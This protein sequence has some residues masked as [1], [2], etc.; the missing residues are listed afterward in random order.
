MNAK[1]LVDLVKVRL[2]RLSERRR[3][4]RVMARRH[5]LGWGQPVGETIRYVAEV[6]GKWVALLVFG[7]AAYALEDRDTWIGW[8]GEQRRGRLN[9][10]AQ[11]RRFLILLDQREPNLASRIL[12]LCTRRLADDWQEAYGHPIVGLETFVDPQRFQGTCYRAAGWEPLGLTEGCRRIRRDWYD[13]SGAPKQLFVK[14]L[15]RDAKSLLCAPEL[16]TAWQ[17]H[18]LGVLARSP[19]RTEH[20]RSLWQAYA[21][22]PEF[23]H[24][25][26]LR[27][28]LA[29]VLAC[30]A[31]AVLAGAEGLGEAAEIIAGLEQRQLRALRCYRR[32]SSGRYEPPSEST[33]RRALSGL[34]TERFDTV[35]AQWVS[36]HEDIAAVALDGKAMR[37]C[38]NAEGKPLFLVSAVAHGTGAF[39]GQVQV[40]GK[41]NEIPAARQLLAQMGPLDGVMV[42]TDA[43]HT[44]VET[45]Q[46]VVLEQ[47]ADYLS[48]IKGNQ[49]SLLRKA[50][51]HLPV[52]HF[53]SDGRTG[54]K[55]KR[56][57]GNP[58]DSSRGGDG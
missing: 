2:M 8:S 48:P 15:R 29:S 22:I 39:Q 37:G 14:L 42:T 6:R 31:C 41:S 17:K 7:A 24:A 11:N 40:D 55:T 57:G 13:H 26:G 21:Q 44:Q 50:R 54:G 56:T 12:G 1:S 45:A 33:L 32:R 49:P 46:V 4:E 34:D 36:Q 35:V 53:F 47:G 9:F 23:R 18:E 25:R 52:D 27:H 43:A 38:L 5:Y 16:P 58:P 19:V 10:L 3:F 28:P 51:R 20:S 30:L